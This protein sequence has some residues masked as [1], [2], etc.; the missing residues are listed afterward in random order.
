MNDSTLRSDYFFMEEILGI[1]PR[2]RKVSKLAEEGKTSLQSGGKTYHGSIASISKKAKRLVQQAQRRGITL[3]VMPQVLERHKNNSSWYCG[4]R[5]LITWKVEIV[6][7][8]GNKTISFNLSELEED[9]LE[10][11][12]R[13]IAET[14]KDD[15]DMPS[16]A[17]SDNYQLVIKRLPTSANNPRY[18]RIQDNQCLKTILEGL[19]IVEHPT[20]YCVTNGHMNE[21]PIGA[22]EITEKIEITSAA[23]DPTDPGASV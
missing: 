4:S 6:L 2:A 11:I 17:S 23:K 5:D 10:H 12:A 19:T 7:V 8:P 13:H 3:Q 14:Y 15:L 18:V 9:I 16:I 20:L 21:F 22:N 1:M